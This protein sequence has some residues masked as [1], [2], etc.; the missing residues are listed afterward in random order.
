[1]LRSARGTLAGIDH[2]LTFHVEP[3][4]RTVLWG[5]AGTPLD[6]STLTQLQA[7][8]ERW[9]PV[10]DSLE[11]LLSRAE[12]VATRNRLD[13]LIARAEYPDADGAWPALPWPAM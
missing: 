13:E 5:W 2:G 10:T 3:K 7:L 1:V 9:G 11:P 8:R 12:I 4:L 6:T